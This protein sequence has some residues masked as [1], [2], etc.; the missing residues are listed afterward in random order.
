[1]IRQF[2]EWGVDV[3]RLDAIPHICKIIEKLILA[4][5]EQALAVV[6]MLRVYQELVNPGSAM[7]AEAVVPREEL[8]D[9]VGRA[10]MGYDFPAQAALM[11][12]IVSGEI[13]YWADYLNE[14]MSSGNIAIFQN[15]VLALTTHDDMFID[16]G[17][18]HV[19]EYRSRLRILASN[20]R[21]KAFGL[22]PGHEREEPPSYVTTLYELCNRNE[23]RMLAT[24]A[25][26]YFAPHKH[27]LSF[28]GMEL[29]RELNQEYFDEV[30]IPAAKLQDRNTDRRALRR[31]PTSSD[32]IAEVYDGKKIKDPFVQ[33]VA[34][35]GKARAKYYPD[36]LKY[37]KIDDDAKA[38][39]MLDVRLGGV[40]D[41]KEV[42]LRLLVNN[43]DQ[44]GR[45][46]DESG[47]GNL[48]AASSSSDELEGY[49]YRLWVVS[50]SK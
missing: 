20:E 48:I 47:D 27:V 4:G 50:K 15:L 43:S 2:K 16:S 22:A 7:L 14:A 12:A 38:E 35:L 19:A 37:Y 13:G 25:M 18:P 44:G 31:A 41:G 40:K 8:P 39:N 23:D 3:T 46:Y 28:N 36:E 1:M 34:D 45:Q 49:G 5:N 11:H 6:A 21:C 9:Y 29:R 17:N 42:N 33:A 26:A 32:E 24:I 30:E 10:D